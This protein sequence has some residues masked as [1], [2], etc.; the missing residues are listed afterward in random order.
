[1]T[2]TSITMCSAA[3]Q[4]RLT[5][6]CVRFRTLTIYN[7]RVQAILRFRRSTLCRC[8]PPPHHLFPCRT[9]S[10]KSTA[11]IKNSSAHPS[12]NHIINVNNIIGTDEIFVIL[13]HN[14]KS[15]QMNRLKMQLF[16]CPKRYRP[17]NYYKQ[18]LP[19]RRRHKIHHD[20]K[21][22]QE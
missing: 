11:F 2:M 22:L 21:C 8:A 7:F 19:L 15:F 10:P 13:F 1:M 14:R 3:T 17:Q 4:V 12:E 6:I 9:L 18:L 5:M 20:G 16:F